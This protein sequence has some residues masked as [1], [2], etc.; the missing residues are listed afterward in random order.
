MVDAKAFAE[1]FVEVGHY[2]GVRQ[3]VAE[4]V[5]PGFV[6]VD[7]ASQLAATMRALKGR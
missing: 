7:E 2:E 4:G 6:P 5:A 3:H 1:Y